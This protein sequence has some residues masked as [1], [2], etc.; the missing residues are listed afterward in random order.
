M[1]KSVVAFCIK[2]VVQY[3]MDLKMLN[4]TFGRTYCHFLNDKDIDAYLQRDDATAGLS[5]DDAFNEK[6]AL[7]VN[8]FVNEL[9]EFK[10]YSTGVERLKQ[11]F[12]LSVVKGRV[13]RCGVEGVAPPKVS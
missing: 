1:E 6:F 8:A 4:E 5:N 12:V 11:A 13:G 3:F 7:F 2:K 10:T 9:T